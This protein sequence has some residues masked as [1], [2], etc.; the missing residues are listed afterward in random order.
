MI[1]LKSLHMVPLGTRTVSLSP[2]AEHFGEPVIAAVAGWA[3]PGA[4]G[5][6]SP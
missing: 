3:L 2:G 6:V 1:F 5:T 4:V